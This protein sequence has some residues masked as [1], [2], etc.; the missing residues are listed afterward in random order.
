MKTIEQKTHT[1]FEI[2]ELPNG[3]IKIYTAIAPLILEKEFRKEVADILCPKNADRIQNLIIL[4]SK[5]SKRIKE[6]EKQ[7]EDVLNC[8]DN[9]NYLGAKKII[10]KPN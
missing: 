10:L 6:L 2:H 4:N 5:S 8:L 7:L 1:S 9:D 3:D